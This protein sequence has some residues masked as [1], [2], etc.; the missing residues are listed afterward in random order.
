M[1][2]LL[3]SISVGLF[4]VVCHIMDVD[5]ELLSQIFNSM[6]NPSDEEKLWMEICV[7]EENT[8]QFSN[9]LK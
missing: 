2:L 8:V 7:M 3:L 1:F 5:L 9:F 6:M 4:C